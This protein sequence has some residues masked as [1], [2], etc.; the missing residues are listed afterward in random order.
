M[1]EKIAFRQGIG[2]IL[3]E[4]VY[5]AALKLGEMKGLNLLKYAVQ[6][7][8]VAIGAHGI[9]SRKDFIS[10]KIAY[11]CSVQAGDHT[12]PASPIRGCEHGELPPYCQI[13]ASTAYLLPSDPRMEKSSIF[14]RR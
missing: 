11:A 14:T 3:A 7:K 8:G 9:R 10:S 5:R 4:G 6:E 1:A 12:S 2:D 13:V